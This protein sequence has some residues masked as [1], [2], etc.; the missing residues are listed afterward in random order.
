MKLENCT[1]IYDY[2]LEKGDEEKTVSSISEALGITPD[3]V[4]KCLSTFTSHFVQLEDSGAYALNNAE[5]RNKESL[6]AEYN[7]KNFKKV[8]LLFWFLIFFTIG[9]S[10]FTVIISKGN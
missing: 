3:E 2:F 5:G 1:K 8:G 6:V 10:L 9:I 4:G 7:S